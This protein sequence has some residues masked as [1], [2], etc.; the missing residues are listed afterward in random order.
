RERDPERQ[1]E[2]ERERRLLDDLERR[3]FDLAG[4]RAALANLGEVDHEAHR[5]PEDRH[6]EQRRECERSAQASAERGGRAHGALELATTSRM[7]APRTVSIVTGKLASFLRRC[8]RCTS[9][10]FVPGSKS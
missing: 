1:R 2:R 6:A 7:P 9:I 10:T 3:I 8:V 4:R 5:D